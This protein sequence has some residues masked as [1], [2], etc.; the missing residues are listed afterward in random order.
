[1]NNSFPI[2][3][4]DSYLIFDLHGVLISKKEMGK[5]YDAFVANLLVEQFGLN[6]IKTQSAIEKANT[7]WLNFWGR[8]NKLTGE[9]FTQA[10]EEYNAQWAKT[11]LQGRKVSDYRQFA[12]FIEYHAPANLCC[13]YPEVKAVL[14]ELSSIDVS[15]ILASSANSRHSTGVLVGCKI[16]HLFDKVIGM[17]HTKARKSNIAFYETILEMIDQPVE[18]C[19][20]IG[21]SGFEIDLPNKLGMKTVHISIEIDKPMNKEQES[22]A[23]LVLPNLTNLIPKIFG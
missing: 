3:I 7:E 18:N 1:M 22:I 10:Y 12:E 21:N 17:E 13:I 6:L 23:D 2:P 15:L 20:Y 5:Q 4:K 9:A 8:S 14:E 19:I 11:I 16:F